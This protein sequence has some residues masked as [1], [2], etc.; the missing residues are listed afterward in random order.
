M[1]PLN[2]LIL[3]RKKLCKN[4]KS[5]KSLTK[6]RKSKKTRGGCGRRRK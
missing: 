4:R 3:T 5:K 2:S 1:F 6:S